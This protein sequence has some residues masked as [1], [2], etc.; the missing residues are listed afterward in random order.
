[1]ICPESTRGCRFRPSCDRT[2]IGSTRENPGCLVRIAAVISVERQVNGL[3]DVDEVGN[4]IVQGQILE[5]LGIQ[6]VVWRRFAPV[7]V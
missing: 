5:S 3:C 6:V 1:M 7:S 4:G 2:R